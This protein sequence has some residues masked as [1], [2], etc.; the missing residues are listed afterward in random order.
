ML[1]AIIR[2]C[3]RTRSVIGKYFIAEKSKLIFFGPRKMFTPLLPNRPTFA[4][5][6][7]TGLIAG[8]PGMANALGSKKCVID[9]PEDSFPLPIRSGRAR[10]L[11]L[12]AGPKL[13]VFEGSKPE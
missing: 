1:V 6:V 7:Q 5:L 8:H 2:N 3:S 10:K 13:F 4:G 9:W 11:L 12:D